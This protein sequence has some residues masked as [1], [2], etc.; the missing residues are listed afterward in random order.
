MLEYKFCL[1]VLDYVMCHLSFLFLL[2][3]FYSNTLPNRRSLLN[4]Q[5]CWPIATW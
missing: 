4:G 1:L 3:P 2:V 5:L